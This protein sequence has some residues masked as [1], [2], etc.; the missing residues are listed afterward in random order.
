[1]TPLSLI[2]AP[3]LLMTMQVGMNQPTIPLTDG[4]A[5]LRDRGPKSQDSFGGGW[6]N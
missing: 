4:H 2:F 3:T 1:M 6:R 5:E